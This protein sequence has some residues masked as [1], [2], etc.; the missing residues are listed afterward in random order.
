VQAIK[1]LSCAAR[2]GGIYVVANLIE[3]QFCQDC[4][5]DNYLIYNSNVAFDANGTLVARLVDYL[6]EWRR[7]ASL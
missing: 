3:R 1:R 2:D 7:A 6:L 4:A 5:A